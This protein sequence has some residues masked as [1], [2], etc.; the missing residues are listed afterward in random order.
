MKKHI[1]LALAVLGFTACGQ[2]GGEENTAPATEQQEG[3]VVMTVGVEQFHQMMTD[4]PGFLL[5][6]RTAQEFEQGHIEGATMI[7]YTDSGFEENVSKLD[8]DQTV[9][10]YCRSGGRSARS[11]AIMKELGFKKVVDLSGGVTAWMDHGMPVA[12]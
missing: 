7:D 10:V 1:I 3:S 4:E 9:Y 6:V 12:E 5:D 8:K 2:T 11:A